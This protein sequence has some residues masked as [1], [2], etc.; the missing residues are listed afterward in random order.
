MCKRIS[1]LLRLIALT[2]I[3]ITSST[4]Q[5]ISA[6][7]N[8]SNFI[9]TKNLTS[10]P[11]AFTENQGQWDE[12]VK[13][14]ANAGGATMWFSPDGAY[15]QF[16]RTVKSKSISIVDKRYGLPDDMLDREPDSIEIM[17]IKA[18][19][20]GANANPVMIGLDMM[21]YK[22][23]YFI[24]NDQS[25]WHTDVPNYTAVMYEEIYDGI[26]LKYY[27]N[28]SQMEYDFIVQRAFLVC[29]DKDNCER[30][31]D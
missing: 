11:L 30:I 12:K 20:V 18:T 9:V 13:F 19:F 29:K 25:K 21:E 22:C 17:M 6:K 27:G 14:R 26:D 10:M 5:T 24:G 8:S 15:Y 3:V 16:N 31:G 28:G 23:N 7:N 4:V 1:P 2:Y